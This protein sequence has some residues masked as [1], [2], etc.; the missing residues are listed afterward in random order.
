MFTDYERDQLKE[1]VNIGAGNAT[2][3]LS[4]LIGRPVTITVPF[5]HLG[6]VERLADQMGDPDKVATTILMKIGGDVSGIFFAVLSRTSAERLAATMTGSHEKEINVMD[7]FD[8]SALQEAGN[9][10][11]GSSLTALSKFTGLS[12]VQSVPEVVTDSLG[13][14]LNSIL[15]E[16]GGGA[17]TALLLTVGFSAEEDIAGEIFFFFDRSS[18]EKILSTVEQKLK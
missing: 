12:F 17:D 6:R 5:I 10:L 9:I 13:A 18:T 15:I 8:R 2:T 1:I 14:T 4:Q 11:A 7:S 3:A 16:I